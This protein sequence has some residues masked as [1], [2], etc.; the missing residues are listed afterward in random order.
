MW[1]PAHI[2]TADSFVE[3][4]LLLA[5]GWTG[6]ALPVGPR[7]QRADAGLVAGS[8]LGAVLRFAGVRAI[9]C[10]QPQR[11]RRLHFSRSSPTIYATNLSSRSC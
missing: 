6:A 5:C 1:F 7:A 4:L 3:L 11:E 2:P 8:V 9:L 10:S